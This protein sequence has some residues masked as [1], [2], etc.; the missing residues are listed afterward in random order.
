MVRLKA[1]SKKHALSIAKISIPYGAIKSL[2]KTAKIYVKKLF[3]F[4]MVR[5][6]D[7]VEPLIKHSV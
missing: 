7:Y 3:Q 5:L 4:L 2:S 1:A 6:K